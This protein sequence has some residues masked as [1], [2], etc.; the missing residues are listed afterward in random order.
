MLVWDIFSCE[1]RARKREPPSGGPPNKAKPRS[2]GKSETEDTHDDVAGYYNPKRNNTAGVHICGCRDEFESQSNDC[3]VRMTWLDHTFKKAEQHGIVKFIVV[4]AVTRER[5]QISVDAVFDG[6]ATDLLSQRLLLKEHGFRAQISEGQ[7]SMTLTQPIKNWVWRF[8]M[9]DGLYQSMVDVRRP[10]PAM[11]VLKK[12]PQSGSHLRPI[13]ESREED[14]SAFP[15][16]RMAKMKRMSFRKTSLKR[17]EVPF[18]K[19]IMDLGFHSEPIME[20]YKVYMHVKDDGSRYQWICLQQNKEETAQKLVEFCDHVKARFGK[21]VNVFHSD[22]GLEFTCRDVARMCVGESIQ[23]F[24]HP[25]TPEEVCLV[26]KAHDVMMNKVRSILY[27]SGLPDILWGE[28]AAYVVETTNRTSTMGNKDQVTSHEKIFGTKPSVRHLRPF[29]CFALTFVD[30]VYRDNKLSR[31][32]AP[33][34]L[35]GYAVKT[36]GCRLLDLATGIISEHRAE[37][38]KFYEQTTVVVGLLSSLL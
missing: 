3:D 4:D 29:V 37:N 2:S 34:L 8:D 9:V 25:D 17:T 35:V 6:G 11:T 36:K 10:K 33:T 19:I 30:K 27:S 12:S 20:G 16:L 1:C 21:M 18:G 38:I 15:K 5:V 14:K 31:R 13:D 7:Q 28:A 24:A 32:G 26:E 22:Q 23:I